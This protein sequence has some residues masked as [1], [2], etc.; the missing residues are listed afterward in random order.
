[1]WV[2]PGLRCRGRV[3]GT[4]GRCHIFQALYV[5]LGFVGPEVQAGDGVV[6]VIIFIGIDDLEKVSV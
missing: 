6:A 1:M 3:D 4:R 2:V 5:L